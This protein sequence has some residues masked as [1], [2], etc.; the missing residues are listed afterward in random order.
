MT[1]PRCGDPLLDAGP[2]PACIAPLPVGAPTT[3]SSTPA[4]R[5]V[6]APPPPTVPSLPP[7]GLPYYP[8]GI[9]PPVA[10][11]VPT[12]ALA[13]AGQRLAAAVLD[14]VFAAVVALVAAVVTAAGIVGVAGADYDDWGGLGGTLL[15][16]VVAAVAATG[17][18]LVAGTGT[19]GQTVGKRC[20][21]I[22]VVALDG[23]RCSAG[24]A[25]GRF[26]ALSGITAAG[27]LVAHGG[28]VLGLL[29]PV[30]GVAGQLIDARRQAW[31]DRMAGTLVF[32]A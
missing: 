28:S 27:L 10:P 5:R 31:L 32:S 19:R 7:T 17:L 2:C 1:C 14:T 29:L 25:A 20:V 23:G 6:P 30:A 22:R 18:N 11:Q 4:H 16:V 21:G 15:I 12:P 9:F 26:L 24:R 8:P 13:S 3:A